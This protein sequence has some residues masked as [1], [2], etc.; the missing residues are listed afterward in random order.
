MLERITGGHLN[1]AALASIWTA[2]AATGGAIADPHL[3]QCAECRVRFAAFT[4]WLDE[5][6]TN[7][8][9]EADEAF[10]AERLIAQQAHIL[11]RLEAAERPSRIIAFPNLQATDSP[12]PA[13]VRR[14]IAAAAAAGLIAGLGIGQMMDFRQLRRPPTLPSDRIAMNQPRSNAPANGVVPASA[15]VSEETLL[16]ELEAVATPKYDTLRAYDQFTPHAADY[17]RPR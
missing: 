13:P 16:A 4:E 5:V 17:I 3:R 9:A 12:R 6:R 1:D 14:W 2:S 10:P 8:I 11:R 15:I 7:A